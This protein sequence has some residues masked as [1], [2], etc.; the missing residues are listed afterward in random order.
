[1]TETGDRTRA[2]IESYVA[3]NPGTHVNQVGRALG[4]APGQ[5]QHHLDRLASSGRLRR[6][7]VYGKSHLYRPEYS[8]VERRRLA[9]FRRETARDVTLDVLANE[10]ARP[11]A[12][13]D[14]LDIARSTLEWHLDRLVEEDVLRKRHEAGNRVT[15]VVV[16]ETETVRLLREIRPSAPERFA[17][18]FTRLVDSLLE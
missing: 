6:E 11:S 13:A 4:L 8:A 14:R 1:M 18:R 9:L 10:P 15:L 16:D 5:L 3:S 2:R 12:V 7:T 17:D